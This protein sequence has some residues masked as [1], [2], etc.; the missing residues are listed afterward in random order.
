M[1]INRGHKDD[2]REDGDDRKD[3]RGNDEDDDVDNRDNN[4]N[5]NREHIFAEEN[6]SVLLMD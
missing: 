5:N 3:S 1:M 4:S 6:Q 2:R